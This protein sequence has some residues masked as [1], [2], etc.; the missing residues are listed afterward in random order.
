M[1]VDFAFLC[2][3]AETTQKI[4][5]MGIGIDNIYSQTLPVKYPSFFLVFQ[6]RVNTVEIGEKDLK[7][8]IIDDDGKSIV[9]EINFK[10][11]VSRPLSGI[12][13]ISRVA[14][15]FNNVDFP[16]YGTYAIHG[17]VDGNDVISLP[18]TITNVLPKT[19]T[20]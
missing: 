19:L 4:N 14:V 7:V 17:I 8:H 12:E 9:P 3:Y 13:S 10:F 16:K 5:A 15:R 6:L 20:P 18:L 2:D 1:K 11:T